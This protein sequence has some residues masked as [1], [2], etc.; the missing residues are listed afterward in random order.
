MSHE[1]RAQQDTYRKFRSFVERELRDEDNPQLTIIPFDDMKSPGTVFLELPLVGVNRVKS[2]ASWEQKVKTFRVGSRLE[3]EPGV[4]DL[5]LAY[6][7]YIPY[8]DVDKNKRRRSKS[9]RQQRGDGYDFF[10]LMVW[11]FVFLLLLVVAGFK[12][13]PHE[14]VLLS[15]L[16]IQ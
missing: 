12:V 14:W 5:S 2:P 13:K 1:I 10:P 8:V 16:F 6:V 9:Y 7:A 3:S 4:Y 15:Q 11:M